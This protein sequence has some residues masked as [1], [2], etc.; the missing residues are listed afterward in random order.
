MSVTEEI[1][2]AV[3][4]PAYDPR[5]DQSA[6][7]R[8]G[9]AEAVAIAEAARAAAGS[10]HLLQNDPTWVAPFARH[11]AEVGRLLNAIVECRSTTLSRAIETALELKVE[12]FK[13]SEY[14]E[15]NDLDGPEET[16]PA[17]RDA[18]HGAAYALA[19]API[20]NAT[21]ALVRAECFIDAVGRNPKTGLPEDDGGNQPVLIECLKSA[22][23]CLALR[24]PDTDDWDDAVRAY[25]KSAREIDICCREEASLGRAA[26]VEEVARTSLAERTAAAL[27]RGDAARNLILGMEPP[28]VDGLL[29]QLE[30]VADRFAIDLVSYEGREAALG[31][32]PL[33]VKRLWDDAGPDQALKLALGLIA[34][35]AATLRDR[36]YPSDW[37][38]LLDG[39]LSVHEGGRDA[40]RAAYDARLLAGDLVDVILDTRD[41]KRQ[42]VL[43]FRTIHGEA[44]QA[45]PGEVWKWE[46]VK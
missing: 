44:V 4:A 20:A 8:N 10:P 23:A 28:H 9:P 15:A 21:D 7:L 29:V 5:A 27:K 13:A 33:T 31:G 43:M 46:K 40:V 2:K 42:P 3:R 11:E 1:T 36:S 14:D 41:G 35:N 38:A 17:A 24:E 19:E 30:V 32:E 26:I 37:R 6:D 18:L 12:A 45:R 16:W 25:R 22:I 39:F 34:T